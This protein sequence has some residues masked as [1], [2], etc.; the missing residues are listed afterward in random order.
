[1][2]SGLRYETARVLFEARPCV[3]RD[4]LAAPTEEAS[5]DFCRSLLESGTPEEAITFCAY[6][7]PERAAI[8]WAHEC[9]GHLAELLDEADAGL[10]PAIADWVAEPDEPGHRA[11]LA[12]AGA[13]RAMTPVG[14]VAMAAV[15]TLTNGGGTGEDQEAACAAAR[16]VN[17][18][19][20]AALARVAMPDRLPMLSAFVEMGTQ[21][22]EIE[23]LR[24]P[25]A[26][27]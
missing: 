10:L 13:A 15:R 4:M 26:V 2:A 22:A 17:A 6:L 21:L 25:A 19:I 12:Q 14:R 11:I 24:Q 27:R 1:M 8:W 20:L 18:G 7:L 9:I 23:A 5:L 16:G 3:A